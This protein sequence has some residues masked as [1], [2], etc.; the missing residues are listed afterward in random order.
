MNKTLKPIELLSVKRIKRNCFPNEDDLEFGT[1]KMITPENTVEEV[2]LGQGRSYVQAGKETVSL[3]HKKV[4]PAVKGAELSEDNN[5]KP[6]EKDLIQNV[7]QF[8][9]E[10]GNANVA[11]KIQVDQETGKN[12]ITVV[13]RETGEV[14]REIPP[15]ETV[16]LEARI[17]KMIGI[18]VDSTT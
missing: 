9:T 17:E 10:M 1:K 14:I 15:E 6:A 8:N 12:L 16:K 4:N 5:V 2:R 11:L 18:F 3:A 7:N 13:D